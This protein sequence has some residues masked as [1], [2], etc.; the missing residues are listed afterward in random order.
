M[1]NKDE[2]NL[3]FLQ[4]KNSR[5]CLYGLGLFIVAV[6]GM[7]LIIL[8][9]HYFRAELKLGKGW[10]NSFSTIESFVSI[11]IWGG[12]SLLLGAV[13]LLFHQAWKMQ[14]QKEALRK[15]ERELHKSWEIQKFL[16]PGAL[17]CFVA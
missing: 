13:F 9:D 11:L 12:G 7:T 17:G 16:D 2:N 10:P 3:T 14:L 8:T 5:I 6:V 15:L 1:E 4:L